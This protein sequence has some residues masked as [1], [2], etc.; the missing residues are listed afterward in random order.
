VDGDA[1]VW[2]GR[3]FQTANGK[4]AHGLVRFTERYRVRCVID[5][6][7]AGRDA[8]EVLG[9][10][11]RGIP[12]VATTTEAIARFPAKYFV[13]GLAP[14]GGRLPPEG[15]A[16]IYEAINAGLNVDSG[17]HDLLSDDPDIVSL[18]ARAGVALRDVR[19][20]PDRRRLHGFSGRIREVGALKVAVLGTD[21]AVGKRTTC[22]LLVHALRNAGITAHMVGT[23]QTAW[24]QGVKHGLVLDTMINDFLAGELEHATVSAWEDGRPQVICIEGQGS[25]LNPAYPGGYEILAACRP[26]KVVLQHAPTRREYDG[27]PGF[28]I[29]PIEQQIAVLHAVSKATVVAIALNH[30][31]LS[32]DQIPDACAE[33]SARTGLP[34]VDPLTHGLDAVVDVLRPDVPAR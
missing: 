22:A 11:A 16:A 33:L 2:C 15:R 28:P 34:C 26:E 23:G 8:G 5:P 29:E 24:M 30:E 18:A 20:T 32:P 31:G 13:I 3:A 12:I 21:S 10:S 14:D 27:F 9:G 25:L 19:A 7:C 6:D 1:I 4:T 17:L